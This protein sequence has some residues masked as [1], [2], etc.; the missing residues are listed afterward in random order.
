[1]TKPYLFNRLGSA[2]GSRAVA[3]GPAATF[4]AHFSIP[5][6]GARAV[7]AEVFGE[8]PNTAR[9]PRALPNAIELG[10]SAFRHSFDIR[11]SSFVIRDYRSSSAV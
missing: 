11:I 3:A 6:R 9:E 2:R 1:M 8:P 5:Q 7:C 4:S 10:H